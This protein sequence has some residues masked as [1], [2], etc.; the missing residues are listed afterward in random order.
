M[1]LIVR[2]IVKV[3]GGVWQLKRV[4]RN[5]PRGLKRGIYRF[6]Y[7][8]YLR[9]YCSYIGHNSEISETIC[10]PHGYFGIFIAGGAKIGKNCVLFQHVTIGQNSL[11]YS[12]TV[13]FPI[14]GDDC[15]IG[16][17]ATIIGG[18]KI[19]NNCRIGANC[20]IYSDIP[21][22]SFVVTNRPVI[23][24]RADM[25]NRFYKWSPEGP[26]YFRDGAWIIEDD[27]EVL[28]RLKGNI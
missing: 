8:E 6:L 27:E 15:Y 2:L 10:L 5:S 1:H 11:P 22:N 12:K 14:I 26:E 20:T 18:V 21:D 28:R 13:G 9:G 25:I 16:A 3:M 17:G 19:G 23:S 4:V 24:Y 7:Y